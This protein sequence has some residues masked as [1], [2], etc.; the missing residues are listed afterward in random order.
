MDYIFG[1]GTGLICG[2]AAVLLAA[3]GDAPNC[4]GMKQVLADRKNALIF[5][6]VFAGCGLIG[7]YAVMLHNYGEN[8]IKLIVLGSYLAS[9]TVNDLKKRE[10]PDMTTI[11]FAV[12]FIIVLF[13]FD[14]PEGLVSGLIGAVIPSAVLLLAR[15]I[16]K[17]SVGLGDIKMLAACGLMCGFPGVL[18]VMLRAALAILVYSLVMLLLK[19]LKLSAELPF[20]P[21][22]LFG[23]LI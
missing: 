4:Q 14:G 15:L 7:A 23:A 19:K 10:I 8:S 5:A 12:I 20:A 16:K 11:V 21:F 2:A 1:I 22:L 6:L 13:W 3:R 18:F 9:V 17:E